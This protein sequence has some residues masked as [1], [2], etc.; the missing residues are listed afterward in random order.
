MGTRE[1]AH[2]NRARGDR[3]ER[4]ARHRVRRPQP[5]QLLPRRLAGR[6][7]QSRRQDHVDR[8][9]DARR[10]RRRLCP[11]RDCRRR[12]EVLTMK[13]VSLLGAALILSAFAASAAAQSNAAPRVFNTAKVK[14]ERGQQIVG[15]TVTSSDPDIYCAMAN[16]SFDFLWIEMQHS[17]LTYQEV[18][19]MIWA[20]RGAPAMPF[21]RVPDSTPGDI[22][23]AMDIGGLGI[24]I[25][26]VDS[27]EEIRSAVEYTM[28]PPRGK[29][30]LGNGQYGALYGN[31]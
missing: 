18:A 6:H 15:G 3:R 4:H 10:Q 31:D 14:L 28:Y 13:R 29:R 9:A 30:S 17:P 12:H 19:R 22:Q 26:L 11:R 8:R 2:E 25:P 27:V 20:C 16:S 7:G 21:I 1:P 5:Q 23:K 24:I